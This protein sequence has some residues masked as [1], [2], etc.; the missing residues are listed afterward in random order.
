M[1]TA[2]SM[3]VRALRL[4]GEKPVGGTLTS[5][6]QTAYL[7]DLNAMLESWSIDSLMCYQIVQ[8]NFSLSTSTGSYTIGS[9]GTFN[10]TRPTRIVDAFIR[11][12]SGYDSPLEIISKE[13]YNT[14][15]EK[16]TDGTYPEYLY[17][18][19]AFVTS[20]ATIRLYPE[21]SAGLTLFID[22][23]KQLQNFSTIG[24]T[25]VLP[26]GYQRAIE[27][28]F[29]IEV[30]GGF[31]PVPAEVIKVAKD[32][33]AAIMKV[34]SPIGILRMDAGIV[35][36]VAESIVAILVPAWNPVPVNTCPTTSPLVDE[37]LSTVVLV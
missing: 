18:D 16:T 6:E 7:A 32:S 2:S 1:A 36:A 28:N 31:R 5:A 33:K 23:W 4:I 8:E 19:A 29:A 35:K 22:S 12:S 3:I 34:N 25:V 14:I 30:A 13:S 10:T 17:Y 20:L 9:G 26:P 27:F 24:T 11:D 15:V 37:I 21:P